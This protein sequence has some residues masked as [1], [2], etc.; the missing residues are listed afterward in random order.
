MVDALAVAVHATEASGSETNRTS[1]LLQTSATVFRVAWN[2]TGLN[3][4]FNLVSLGWLKRGQCRSIFRAWSALSIDSKSFF[5]SA[6]S[7]IILPLT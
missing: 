1:T 6:V 7:M 2:A 3:A 5:V 4:Q